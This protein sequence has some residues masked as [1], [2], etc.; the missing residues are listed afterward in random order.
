MKFPQPVWMPDAP[1]A[2]VADKPIAP[3]P[4]PAAPS[5]APAPAPAAKPAP[6]APSALDAA[7]S[8]PAPPVATP[9]NWPDNWRELAAGGDKKAAKTIE[10]F[11]SP[12]DLFKSYQEATAKISKG[13]KG[14]DKPEGDAATPEALAAWRK[15][16]GIP[17]TP[18]EYAIPDAV[19]SLVTDEDKPVIAAFTEEMHKR[20]WNQK[21]VADGLEW[22]YDYQA[23]V[24]G[25]RIEADKQ[26]STATQDALREEWGKEFKTNSVYAKRM[27]EAI[28]PDLDWHNAR[29]PDGRLLGNVPEFVKSLARTGIDTFGDVAFAGT[30]AASKT[31]DEITRLREKMKT[32]DFT[33]AD[34]TRLVE[35]T[36]AQMKAG[37]R[38]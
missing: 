24:E 21:Q 3:T 15:E 29:L 9:T 13:I 2:A 5:P 23:T 4:A 19:K 37:V 35:L 27:A 26:A 32:D 12:S 22:F 14:P 11:Q 1:A 20:D 31:T 30:E 25:A 28:M 6:A 10:R 18:T 8:D 7:A 16:V 36:D 34:R 38:K 33:P 17:G